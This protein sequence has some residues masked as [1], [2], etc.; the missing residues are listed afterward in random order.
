[1]ISATIADGCK[2][3]SYVYSIGILWF[4]APTDFCRCWWVVGGICWLPLP[5]LQ[6]QLSPL[7]WAGSVQQDPPAWVKPGAGSWTVQQSSGNC[8]ASI[9][10]PIWQRLYQLIVHVSQ[11]S[12]STWLLSVIM[13]CCLYYVLWTSP[14]APKTHHPAC[15]LVMCFLPIFCTQV[16]NT[17]SCPSWQW[18]RTGSSWSPVRTLPV[19]P[20]WCDLGFVQN[21]RGNKAAANL[22]PT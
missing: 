17:V 16:N 7:L 18:H 12:Q 11:E 9:L 14:L 5:W 19:V 13:C 20:L 21:S 4:S 2:K 10:P 6:A 22:R 15:L 1:M 3:L 8:P